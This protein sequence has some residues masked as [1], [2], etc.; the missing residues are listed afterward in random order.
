[1]RDTE[2]PTTLKKR[3][4][5]QRRSRRRAI[6][7]A[8]LLPLLLGVVVAASLFGRFLLL[9]QSPR[10]GIAPRASGQASSYVW[11]GPLVNPQQR[12]LDRELDYYISS[13]SLDDEL[14][15]MI[16]VQFVGP[17]LGNIYSVPDSW[18][19]E[20]ARVHIGSVIFYWYNIQ[21]QS[22]VQA[23][24]ASLQS[25]AIAPNI[26]LLI[27]TDAEGGEV[28]NLRRI[29]G[30]SPTAESLGDSGDPQKAYAWGRLDAQHLKSV[31]INADLA[32]VVD[33]K[34][35]PNPS[36]YDRI[37]GSDPALVTNMASAFLDGLHSQGMIGTLKHWPG[38]GWSA[39][40]AHFTLP[41]SNRSR[42][43]LDRLDFAPYKAL[44]AS[45]KVDMVMSTH[46]LLTSID[47][48][49]PSSL[50]PIIIDGILRQQLGFQGVVITDALYMHALTQKYSMGESAVLAV[51]AGNDILSSFFSPAGVVQVLAALHHAIGTGRISKARIDQSVKRILRLKLK[52][53]LFN[54]PG[55]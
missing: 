30:S 50:S 29:Y 40:D 47:P 49:M 14:G 25:P 1:M 10:T 55:V 38:L 45:G 5:A 3:D 36:I 13:M 15:Q 53:G 6:W 7:T 27:A 46:V 34:T 9:R 43:D 22:Q 12:A 41:V 39:A 35:V 32:P 37:F 8:G 19:A 26:P 23:L 18:R 52:Y 44:L 28:D 16:Q 17:G 33:V 51:I 48:T 31:G 24:T 4:T 42:A 54:L 11:T 20:L 21:S 2:E